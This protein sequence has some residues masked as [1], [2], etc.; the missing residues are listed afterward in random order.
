MSHHSIDVWT[1]FTLRTVACATLMGLLE[2][3]TEITDLDLQSTI[4]RIYKV[5][6]RERK[7]G[8]MAGNKIGVE[9]AKTLSEMIKVNTTFT[10][11]NLE[12]EEE[13]ERER[14]RRKGKDE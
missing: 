9:G 12:S 4:C 8:W 3:H 14:E 6:K 10:S 13:R 7:D 2:K 1:G 11:L 5:G